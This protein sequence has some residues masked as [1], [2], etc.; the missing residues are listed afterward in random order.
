VS[1]LGLNRPFAEKELW[2]VLCSMV[3]VLGVLEDRGFCHHAVSPRS[4]FITEE[5]Q[6]KL[7]DSLIS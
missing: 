6:V 1:R 4:I 3:V 5:G 7:A 2:S